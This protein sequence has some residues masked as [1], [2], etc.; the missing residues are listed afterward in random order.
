L[1][2]FRHTDEMFAC[3]VA[4]DARLIAVGCESGTVHVFSATTEP[5]VAPLGGGNGSIVA[6]SPDGAVV[7][8]TDSR[9]GQAGQDVVL[10]DFK[11]KAEVGR[12]HWDAWIGALVFAPDGASLFASEASIRSVQWDLPSG[13]VRH[14][15]T[16]P[17]PAQ[18]R[19]EP[20]RSPAYTLNGRNQMRL[21]PDGRTLAR[22]LDD[23]VIGL[24]DVPSGRWIDWLDSGSPDG[25][26]ID[27][28]AD[29]G[30][31]AAH[32][33]GA[34][35]LWDLRTRQPRQTIETEKGYP[36]V[37]FGPGGKALILGVGGRL[38]ILDPHTG[39][40]AVENSDRNAAG[41]SMAFDAGGD[42]LFASAF[43]S[44]VRL[45]DL[46]T[47]RELLSLQKH[48]A[49]ITSLVVTPDGNTLIS[50]DNEGTALIWDLSRYSDPIRREMPNRT[51]R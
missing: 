25:A 21:S 39:R 42:V 11:T 30:T 20:G 5:H 48:T 49:L 13:A 26:A 8:R 6:L 14:E 43:D 2:T 18:H 28:S 36:V 33:P 41:L 15:F 29:G 23:G 44:S 9:D 50:A 51:A 38:R 31:L 10:I 35:I 17:D 32:H 45:W 16:F 12:F 1:A 4:P 19:R 3:A 40:T 37:R 27:F 47:G 24:W 7:A 22:A 46:R 34:C